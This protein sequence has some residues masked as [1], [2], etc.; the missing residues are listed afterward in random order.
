GP[1]WGLDYGGRRASRQA[2]QGPGSPSA[3]LARA[4]RGARPPA[5]GA[6]L[7][8]PEGREAPDRPPLARAGGRADRGA[9]SDPAPRGAPLDRQLR[10]LGIDIR[11]LELSAV[12]GAGSAPAA[13]LGRPGLPQSGPAR[14]GTRAPRPRY[15][16]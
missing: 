16:D 10:P 8:P 2:A 9:G 14:A 4:G 3:R 12:P 13:G 15:P 5:A 11:P 1:G 6:S 7:V